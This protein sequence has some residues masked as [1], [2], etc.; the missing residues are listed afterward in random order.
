[1]TNV[2]YALKVVFLDQNLTVNEEL[3]SSEYDENK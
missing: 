2:R 3:S 1:M